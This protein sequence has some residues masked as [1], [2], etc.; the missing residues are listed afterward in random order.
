M[1][2]EDGDD[3]EAEAVDADDGG[4][5]V[6]VV[7]VRS[8][9]PDADAHGPDENKGVELLP[10]SAHFRALNHFGFQLA[11]QDGGIFLALLA[12]LDNGYLLCHISTFLNVYILKCL[13]GCRH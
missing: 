9:G 13:W 10:L 7:D 6:L 11:L 12:N 3:V 5:L 1:S 2:A 4:I 8:D